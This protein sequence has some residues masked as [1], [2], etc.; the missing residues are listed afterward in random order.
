MSEPTDYD[1]VFCNC[2]KTKCERHG[3]CDLCREYHYGKGKLP[4]CERKNGKEMKKMN[5]KGVKAKAKEECIS[6]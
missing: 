5:K 6:E 3:L 4:Y 2:P 1:I